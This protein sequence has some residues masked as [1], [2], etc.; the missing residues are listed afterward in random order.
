MIAP[1][2]ERFAFLP[3]KVRLA[4]FLRTRSQ[5]FARKT[6]KNKRKCSRFFNKI[7]FSGLKIPAFSCF[8]RSG[9]SPFEVW[10][11]PPGVSGGHLRQ[12]LEKASLL[13]LPRACW[14]YLLG[15]FSSFFA[16]FSRVLFPSFSGGCLRAIFGPRG[17][18]GGAKGRF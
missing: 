10:G 4:F 5:I 3:E 16:L 12:R 9:G 14:R 2:E 1:L 7:V 11:H 13:T 8:F 6:F 15:A 18:P 17:A